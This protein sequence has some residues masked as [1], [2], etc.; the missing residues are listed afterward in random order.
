[1]TDTL[2]AI[3]KINAAGLALIESFEGLRLKAYQDSVGVWTIGFGSTRGVHPG[4]VIT[5]ATAEAMLESDL[6]T[7]ERGVE[8]CISKPL[9]DNQ[10]AA[11][12]SLAFNI[13]TAGFAHS[14]VAHFINA[15]DLQKAADCFLPYD[16]AGGHELLGLKRR[17]EAERGLFLTA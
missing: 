11:C 1:M 6:F 13:G 7:A 5:R 15:G 12:V 10:Y 2:T 3:R 16:H 14:S 4:M 9:T 8:A 17:R